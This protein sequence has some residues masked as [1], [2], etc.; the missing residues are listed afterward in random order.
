MMNRR[1]FI[2]LLGGAAAV[3][4][5]AARAQQAAM[6]LVGV[7]GSGS[8][9]F[10]DALTAGLKESGYIDGHNLPIE[11][12]WAEGAYNHLPAMAE[13]L[14]KLRVDVL[15]V[16]GTTAAHVAKAASLKVSPPLPVVFGLGADPVAAG[17]VASLNRPGGNVTGLTSITNSLAPKRLE[18]LSALVGADA[19]LAILVN[20]A[21]GETERAGAEAAARAVGRTLE[22]FTGRDESEIVAAFAALKTRRVGA[23]IIQSDTFY[24]G[25]MRWIAAL[26][27]RQAIPAIG[28]LREFAAA[29]GLMTYA[30]SLADLVRQQGIYVGKILKGARPADLP[31]MQPTKFE[32]TI[33]LR[34]A[35]ALGLQVPDKLLAIADE[36]IE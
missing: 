20:P 4:P 36:V 16:L 19:V 25:Q 11:Y 32:L 13:E 34:A 1:A 5:F 15:A 8:A 7:L 18:L 14:V 26:S 22:V 3:W 12:R 10:K 28:P 29:G 30:P 23:L 31:V 2:S 24:L 6:P 17:L 33:N 21:T 27:A 9:Q 35:K